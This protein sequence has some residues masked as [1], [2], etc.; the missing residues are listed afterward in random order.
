M[1][2]QKPPVI[3]NALNLNTNAPRGLTETPDRTLENKRWAE[4]AQPAQ[5]ESSV[6]QITM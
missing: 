2:G 6:I 1:I 5:L 4:E 3:A